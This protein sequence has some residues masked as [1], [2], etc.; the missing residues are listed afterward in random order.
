MKRLRWQLVVVVIT[1]VVI[2]LLLLSQQ[3][4]VLPGI[5]EPVVQPTSG[6]AYSEALIGS[7]HRLNPVL[8][9]YNTP[10]QD[11]NRLLYCSLMSFDERALPSG[12]VIETW[13]ISADGTVYNFSIR[14]NAVWH[15]GEPVTSEDVVYTTGL[16]AD[17]ELPAPDDLKALW[18]EIDVVPLD[19][20]TFQMILPEPFA[21]FLDYLTFGL[22]PA[23]LLDGVTAAELVDDEF[24]LNPVG[25]GPYRY[26]QLLVTDGAISGVVL[27][28]FPEY[29]SQPAYIEEVTFKTYLDAAAALLAYHAG[30]VLGVSELTPETLAEGLQSTELN[31][32]SGRL[33][34]LE[35]ILFNLNDPG[36]PFLQDSALRQAL[37]LGMNR[38]RI[39]DRLLG[40]QAIPADGPIFPG[41]W[42]Y[43]ENMP[44]YAFDPERAL[45]L[46]KQE[47]YN[48]TAADSS[49]RAKEGEPA[50][51][52]ELIHPDQAPYPEIAAAIQEDWARLGVKITLTALPYSD[53]VSEHLETR[54]FAAALVDLDFTGQHDPDPYAFWHDTQTTSGQNYTQWNDRQASEYLEQARIRDDYGERARLYRNFQVRFA[55]ELPALPLF[56]PVYSYGIDQSIQGASIGSLTEPNDRLTTLP[57]WFLESR[58]TAPT[59]APEL[60]PTP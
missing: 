39:I 20:K 37:L 30:E 31:L 36:L 42:A 60:T 22:L 53:L 56:Y 12:D 50:L 34:R 52:F 5:V 33:P 2:A 17:P 13:G 40:G 11:V 25:C 45:N 43:Y 51:E 44:Q 38:Q 3:P 8:D 6:G 55:N 35:L 24:N 29:Y 4:G 27:S 14:A 46:L 18:A 15:D 7:L 59:A 26:E 58:L 57:T 1:L 47:G 9:W 23:H 49:L 41:T 21:P 32:Y 16:L 48:P 54:E 28:A 19:D 10:D